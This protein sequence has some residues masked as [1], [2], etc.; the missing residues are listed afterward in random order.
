MSIKLVMLGNTS[1]GKSCLVRRFI[2]NKFSNFQEPTIGAAF[3]IKNM[4]IDNEKMRLEIWD[5][6]GQERYRSLAPMY[7][8][9][10]KVAIIC[11][12]I[13]NKESFESSKTWYEEIE[14]RGET[15]CIKILVGT[16]L[17][18]EHERKVNMAVEYAENKDIYH[19]ETSSKTGKN[20]E[21]LFNIAAI[22]GDKISSEN[23][24][25]RG[26]NIYDPIYKKQK[27]NN[28]C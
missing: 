13:T 14:K 24:I 17:D 1:T 27:G 11:Y 21:H 25:N 22:E 26:N 12:D 10:A 5:T 19:I 15:D 4:T 23:N 20:I 9:R 18:L 2:T 16:K 7:Y 28:C 6:A 3:Q 8:R